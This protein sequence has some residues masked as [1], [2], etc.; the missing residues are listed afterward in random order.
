MMHILLVYDI[1]T[2][3]VRAKVADACQDYGLDRIQYSAFTGQLSSNH[4][5]EL[6]RRIRVLLDENPS[7]ITLV[8]ICDADWKKRQEIDHVG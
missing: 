2:D 8:P 1:T 5:R 3:R 6:M 4:Q 7:K